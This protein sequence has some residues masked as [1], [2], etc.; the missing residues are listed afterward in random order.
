MSSETDALETD[1]NV[2][3]SSKV[4]FP[5]LSTCTM[6]VPGITMANVF[7]ECLLCVRCCPESV[8]S[9]ILNSL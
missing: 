4:Y 5:N 8:L 6:P 3:F 7:I 1:L 9:F 2:S